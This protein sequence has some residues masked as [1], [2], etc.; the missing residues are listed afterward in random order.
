MSARVQQTSNARPLPWRGLRRLT[1]RV[2]AVRA[3]A[4]WAVL[5]GGAGLARAQSA[6]PPETTT[7]D[8]A[9]NS[10]EWNG[11]NTLSA[12]AQGSGLQVKAVSN[13]D[14][15][16][17]GPE[18]ILFVLYPE[19]RLDPVP[20]TGFI[21][22]GGNV[23]I[24]D[25]FGDST[26]VLGRLGM[27]RQQGAG[28]LA[29]RYYE[30]LE[31]APVAV[32]A[33]P[34]HP[35]AEEVAELVTNVPGVLVQVSGADTV[36]HFGPDKAVVVTGTLGRGRFV[37]LSDPS[38]LINRMLQFE[39]N[40]RFAINLLR[41]LSRDGKARR[42]VLL[43]GDF[44]TFGEASELF[45]DD[46]MQSM[47]TGTVTDINRLLDEGNDYLLTSLA[48]RIIAVLL[49]ILILLGAVMSIPSM[50]AE[51]LTGSWTRAAAPASAV[52]EGFERL[53]ARYDR[54]GK[55]GKPGKRGKDGQNDTNGPKDQEANFALPAAVMR[56]SVNDSVAN[57]LGTPD[58]LYNATEQEIIDAVRERAGA[59]AAAALQRVYKQ[60]KALPSRAQAASQWEAGTLSRRDFE[61]L[62]RDVDR[63]YLAI[64]QPPDFP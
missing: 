41:Y 33:M 57:L 32:P 43:V 22:N 29:E 20:V 21:R 15:A 53:V 48:L 1:A 8:Y 55:P 56:D 51:K 31:H 7:Q 38:M 25:D 59:D 36:F 23:L 64:G 45:G 37:V 17:L 18:D 63:L 27:L 44:D 42:L 28:L 19:A 13:L 47:V 24:A 12:V 39:G 49:A 60:L 34:D 62:H 35:L 61:Q 58:P 54:S 14:W 3:L 50:R 30:D 46:S 52:A 9:I 40:L 10:P 16:D 4:V 2:L 26:E 6:P 11:L 5:A